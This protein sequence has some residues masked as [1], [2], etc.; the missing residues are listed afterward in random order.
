[1]KNKIKVNLRN[2]YKYHLNVSAGTYYAN[3]LIGLMYEVLT[4]RCKH[5][6]K[7]EGWRD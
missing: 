1:M 5:W 3:T 6:I 2:Q 7:G 4:H